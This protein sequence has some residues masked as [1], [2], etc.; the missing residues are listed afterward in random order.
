MSDSD[1]LNEVDKF[2]ENSSASSEASPNTTLN[3]FKFSCISDA[4]VKNF[5][6]AREAAPIANVY[7]NRLFLKAPISLLMPEVVPLNL[8]PVLSNFFIAPSALLSC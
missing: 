5:P 6:I 7:N 2:L 3:W 8:P 1:L 4:A